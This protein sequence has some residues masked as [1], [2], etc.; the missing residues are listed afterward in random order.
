MKRK[1][2]FGNCEDRNHSG[3]KVSHSQKPTYSNKEES[4]G[5]VGWNGPLFGGGNN[6]KKQ[7]H[8]TSHCSAVSNNWGGRS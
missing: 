6:S 1:N 3:K 2:N 7:N 5:S 8:S 4:W